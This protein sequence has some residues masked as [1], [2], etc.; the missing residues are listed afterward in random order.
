[1]DIEF[2]NQDLEDYFTGNYSGKQKFSEM[3]LQ[4]FRQKINLMENAQN[5]NELSR[6]RSLNIEKFE[7]HW[8][9][10][11]NAQ[12]RIEFDFEKPNSLWIIKISNHYEK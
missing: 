6:I 3:I 11:I 9:A 4:A 7:D 10:R 12:Y 2:S 1:M 5:L 8:S